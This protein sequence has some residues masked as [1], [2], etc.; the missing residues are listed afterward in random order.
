[1][2]LTTPAVSS[3]APGPFRLLQAWSLPLDL[4][5]AV[6]VSVWIP[7]RIRYLR[8][9]PAPARAANYGEV[10]MLKRDAFEHVLSRYPAFRQQ[11]QAP[12]ATRSGDT[13]SLLSGV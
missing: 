7:V 13:R 10:F 2:P 5:V 6:A 3:A 8:P 12:A 1:M 11:L 9:V 4:V